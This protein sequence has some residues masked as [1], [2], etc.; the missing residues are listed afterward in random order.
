MEKRNHIMGRLDRDLRLVGIH[1]LAYTT[2][3]E[4]ARVEACG[5]AT[6]PWVSREW[7]LQQPAPRTLMWTF[8]FRPAPHSCLHHGGRCFRFTDRVEFCSSF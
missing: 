1:T 6:I 7:H 5:R 8:I 4:P 2:S 3:P